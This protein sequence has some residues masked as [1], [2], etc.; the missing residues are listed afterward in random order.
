MDFHQNKTIQENYSVFDVWI[1]YTGKNDKHKKNVAF[2]V[3]KVILCFVICLYRNNGNT[4][5]SVTW[6]KIS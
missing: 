1:H 5:Q 2:L 4:D 3:V 6:L